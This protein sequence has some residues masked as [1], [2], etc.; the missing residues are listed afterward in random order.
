MMD[1]MR[2]WSSKALALAI[3]A[4]LA[5]FGYTVVA[6][7]FF[8]WRS[9]N[10]E[11]INAARL[12]LGRLNAAERSAKAD[13]AVTVA[14]GPDSKSAF[15]D[16][17]TDARRIANLQAKLGEVAQAVG[18]RLSSTQSAEAREREGVRLI[19]VQTQFTATLEELQSMLFAI[20]TARPIL[21]AG[22][23]GITRQ[24]DIGSKESNSLDVRLVVFGAAP[25][26][27]GKA[28]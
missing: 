5:F 26:E 27:K 22:S 9:E 8:A 28:Q 10:A 16:G 12:L 6:A 3:L 24:P 18:A 25:P 13:A 11:Q 2:V 20:E 4:T 21:I 7:P 17:D 15:L 23:L 14:A 19:G 1:R